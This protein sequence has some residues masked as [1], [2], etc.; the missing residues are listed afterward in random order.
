MCLPVIA[1]RAFLWSFFAFE[2]RS[3]VAALPEDFSVFEEYVPI[4]NVLRKIL[5]T[6][7][8]LC[9]DFGNIPE[10]LGKLFE[11]LFFRFFCH[12]G[13]HIVPLVIFTFG[14]SLEVFCGRSYS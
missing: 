5:V 3:A 14:C 4:F 6:F 1:D 8:M 12:P 9:F 11:A 2:Y 7:F 13:I 10:H